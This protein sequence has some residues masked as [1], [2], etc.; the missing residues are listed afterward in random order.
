MASGSASPPAFLSISFVLSVS[1]KSCCPSLPFPFAAFFLRPAQ[2]A[3]FGLEVLEGNAENGAAGEDRQDEGGK[4]RYTADH[5]HLTLFLA[6]IC[7][8]HGG[9]DLACLAECR[10]CRASCLATRWPVSVSTP[11][12]T[13]CFERGL[14]SDCG[15]ENS[16]SAPE[17][18]AEWCW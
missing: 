18:G 9:G 3:C 5:F 12:K 17:S 2:I 13:C 6:W 7:C 15:P 8:R 14:L 1:T 11:E 10:C 16:D 4:T